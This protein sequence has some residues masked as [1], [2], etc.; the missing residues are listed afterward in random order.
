ME[1]APRVWRAAGNEGCDVEVRSHSTRFGRTISMDPSADC[2]GADRDNDFRIRHCLNAAEEGRLHRSTDGPGHEQGIGEP[3][4]SDHL[5]PKARG[6]ESRIAHRSDLQIGSA[7]PG[8]NHAQ[9]NRAPEHLARRWGGRRR[10]LRAPSQQQVFPP[11]DGCGSRPIRCNRA[12]GACRHAGAAT[13]APSPVQAHIVPIQELNC[14]SRTSRHAPAASSPR[15]RR[16]RQPRQTNCSGG[17][18]GEVDGISRVALA[19]GVE[20]CGEHRSS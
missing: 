16:V 15:T 2:A 12:R 9:V 1:D 20:K 7:A 10:R 11:E 17:Q 4:R 18:V 19:C 13:D 8:R 5:N 3:R 14:A 6:I